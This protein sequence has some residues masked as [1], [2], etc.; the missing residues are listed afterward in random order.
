LFEIIDEYPGY[1]VDI[2]NFVS[3]HIKKISK[4]ISENIITLYKVDSNRIN[5]KEI[6]SDYN[7]L[8]YIKYPAYRASMA[9]TVLGKN[10]SESIVSLNPEHVNKFYVE[11]FGKNRNG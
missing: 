5:I 10:D 8:I 4:E 11:L 7:D 6:V 2:T 9:Q 1:L 3:E